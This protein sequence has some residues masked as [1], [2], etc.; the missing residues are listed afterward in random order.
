MQG[1]V[2]HGVPINVELTNVSPWIITV[3]I[4]IRNF[5]SISRRRERYKSDNNLFDI[6][7]WILSCKRDSKFCR[8][9]E[10][11]FGAIY[12]LLTLG[13]VLLYTGT[14][15]NLLAIARN[16]SGIALDLNCLRE[17]YSIC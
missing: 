13:V 4:R 14:Q 7:A 5:E 3:V 16:V 1:I 11:N 12:I 10:D 6:T 15:V 8:W 17:D 9:V 2:T